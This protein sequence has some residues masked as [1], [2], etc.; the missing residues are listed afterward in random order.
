MSYKF[1][2]VT[3]INIIKLNPIVSAWRRDRQD[4]SER[5]DALIK[6]KFVKKP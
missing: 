4:Y 5:L 2:Q 3:I 1:K 6:K